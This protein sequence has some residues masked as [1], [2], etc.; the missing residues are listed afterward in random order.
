ME[1]ILELLRFSLGGL[2]LGAE[3]GGRVWAEERCRIGGLR[4]LGDLLNG[5]VQTPI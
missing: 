4:S 3:T 1:M 5:Q 2:E